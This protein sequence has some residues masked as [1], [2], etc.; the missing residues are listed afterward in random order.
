LEWWR[1]VGRDAVI[2]PEVVAV[3]D[4]LLDPA[5]AQRVWADSGG[6]QRRRLPADGEFCRR[7]GERLGRP[8]LGPLAATDY[9]GP[10]LAWMGTVIR[11]RRHPGGRPGPYARFDEN[12]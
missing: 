2:F 9:G 6:E 5:M 8:W 4:A 12:L 11:L 1:V 7:L 10:L 3:A